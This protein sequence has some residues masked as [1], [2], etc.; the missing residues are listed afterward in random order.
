M[1][2]K[3]IAYLLLA[4]ILF[5]NLTACTSKK[6]RGFAIVIDP[7][8]YEEAEEQ[9][10]AYTTELQKSGLTVYLV[11]DRWGIPDSI[12]QELIS[13]YTANK[14]PIEGAILLGDIPVA[15]IRDGQHLTSAFKMDQEKYPWEDSS[16]P[17]DRFYDDFDLQFDFL[18]QDEEQP[19]LFYYSLNAN[20]AQKLVCNIYTGRVRPTDSEGSSR[21]EKLRKFLEKAVTE[22][23]APNVMD[24]MLFFSGHG[25][26]SESQ[27]ARFDEKLSFYESFPW[28]RQQQNGIEYIDHRQARHIKFRLMD[29]LQRDNLDLAIL[30]HH[31]NWDTQY[32]NG[33]P[34]A[35]TPSAAIDL[36]KEYLRYRLRRA[37]EKG[38]NINMV[39][40]E[41]MKHFDVPQSWFDGAFDP[42]IIKADS[43]D[44]ADYDLTLSD[45]ADFNPQCRVILLDACFNG[46]FHRENSIANAY[47]FGE[48][49]RT[50]AVA[51]NS[52]NVLQ[53]KWTDR[54]MG[55]V[56]L[57][58]NIGRMIQMNAFLES[59][60]IGDPTFT[61][62]PT[63]KVPD[64]NQAIVSWSGARWKKELNKTP[65]AAIKTLAIEE[66]Y[67]R[68]AIQ[69]EELLRIFQES[70][71][72]IVRMEAMMTLA[73]INDDRFIKCL[74]LAVNDSH[75]MVARF[76][77]NFIAQSG[78]PRLASAVISVA[79]RNNTSERVNFSVK[80][81]IP[82]F[83]HD[84]L[85]Q[86]FN[87]QFP[88]THYRDSASV[89]KQITQVLENQANRYSD[90]M[91]EI[92]DS[93]QTLKTRIFY[94]RTM[95][96]YQVHFMVPE[97]LE[98][99]RQSNDTV[100]QKNML[101]AFGWF[102]LSYQAPEIIKTV[103]EMSQDT[104]L[105]QSVRNE[106]LKTIK[107]LE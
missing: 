73:Q 97:L 20:S 46:S 55:A 107:R 53:D 52:V 95:R 84:I 75:E 103:L 96:N 54:Y 43:I 70:H 47:I 98:Y 100:I 99:M 91:E 5:W 8:S 85:M 21:Y 89:R 82:L 92:I 16:V 101:E 106:A 57:G 1:K 11:I 79:I 28:L 23:Q 102:R 83:E 27:T 90:Y 19:H 56:A 74:S 22:K 12:R 76:A 81:A 33:T 6:E 17:S 69:S 66:L 71:D 34:E 72:A 41:I 10:S 39:R 9:L 64:L 86:E 94:I 49:N 45:F 29:E 105:P 2:T 4:A 32:M 59:H 62:T 24:Q 18:K 30:H 88:Q 67:R 42:E 26:A 44:E 50:I 15:M 14:A 13:L 38:E 31:G 60:L 65:Y 48:N 61:F 77:M 93:L 58:M 37:Q 25:Y 3:N 36:V 35:S 80:S 63:V 51:A 78:D 68:N 40:T 7:Q 104:A 87:R